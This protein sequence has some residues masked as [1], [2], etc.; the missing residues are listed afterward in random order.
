MGVIRRGII[1]HRRSRYI[2]PGRWL[3]WGP[4]VQ[5]LIITP[6]KNHIPGADVVS[7]FGDNLCHKPLFPQPLRQ[8]PC[9]PFFGGHADMEGVVEPGTD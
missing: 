1:N 2:G 4:F 9:C 6:E 7:A 3:S 5:I 8:W